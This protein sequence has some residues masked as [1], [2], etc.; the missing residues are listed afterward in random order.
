MSRDPPAGSEDAGPR[1]M[2]FEFNKMAGALLGSLLFIMALGIVS[3]GIFSHAKLV[4]PGYDLPAPEAAA[5]A[6]GPAAAPTV[7]LPV[8]LA[9]ADVKKGEADTKVCQACHNFEKGAGAKVGPPLYGVVDRPKGSVAGFGYSEGMK[10]KGG[11]WTYDD[12]NAF[13][14]NPKAYVS[15]TK[16]AYAGESDPVKRADIIDYLHTLSDDPKPLPAVAAAEPPAAGDS[17]KPVQAP[18]KADEPAPAAK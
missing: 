9:K 4:K 5:P 15:G 7:P 13:I 8:L 6:G 18:A 12:L 2:S 14:T 3:D 17:A 16:M 10:A 1:G 11:A